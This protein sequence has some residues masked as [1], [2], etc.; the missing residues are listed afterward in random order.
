M[1]I[2]R[3]PMRPAHAL[4][5]RC[6][7]RLFFGWTEEKRL[8]KRGHLSPQWEQ[9]NKLTLHPSEDVTHRLHNEMD[10]SPQSPFD[11]IART[12]RRQDR[13]TTKFM[14]IVSSPHSPGLL[15]TRDEEL[16]GSCEEA[17]CPVLPTVKVNNFMLK[18]NDRKLP[19]STL[20][21]TE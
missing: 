18:L 4:R 11:D 14:I 20:C 5:L 3:A 21:A 7:R 12:R 19:H 8:W 16:V 2:F 15:G 9:R 1:W 10:S 13:R 17:S 6:W